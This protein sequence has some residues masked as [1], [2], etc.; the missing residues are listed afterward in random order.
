[1]PS[2]GGHHHGQ[3]L[4]EIVRIHMQFLRVQHAQL[5]VGGLDVVHVLHSTVQ[6]VEDSFSVNCNHWVCFDGSRVVEVS[7]VSKVPLS[8]G[9]DN[10]TPE[11]TLFAG[12]LFVPQLSA[13]HAPR[14][15]VTQVINSVHIFRTFLKICA[16]PSLPIFWVSVI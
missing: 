10:Q 16:D 4:L 15:S 5:C 1:L 13:N 9:V 6:T 2:Q 12:V 8:P 11:E 3:E 14:A 7:K